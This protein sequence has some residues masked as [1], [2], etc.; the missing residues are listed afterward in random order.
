MKKKE[1][2]IDK[3]DLRKNGGFY[4]VYGSDCYIL[5][6]LFDYKIKD[7]RVGFPVSA[8]EKVVKT[9]EENKISYE[10]TKDSYICNTC[11]KYNKFLDLGKKKCN[12]KYRMDKIIEKLNT[13]D[14][15]K[16][17]GI[18]DIIEKYE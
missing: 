7:D 12:L 5:N 6:Y 15:K 2:K 9:L 18:L 14:E 8:Y 3:V 1:V 16:L 11:N 10:S 17:N 4:C 13:F